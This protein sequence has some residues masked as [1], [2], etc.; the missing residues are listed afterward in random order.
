[1]KNLAEKKNSYGRK[2]ETIHT[3]DNAVFIHGKLRGFRCFT[4][5]KV[6]ETMMGDTCNECITQQ[7]YEQGVTEVINEFTDVYESTMD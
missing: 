3:T 2:R 7:E 4:C 6:D 5:G 1:M